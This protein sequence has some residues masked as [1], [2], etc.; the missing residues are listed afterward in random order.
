MIKFDSFYIIK[1]NLKT[2]LGSCGLERSVLT[3]T[4]D[5]LKSLH[6]HISLTI[7]IAKG[8]RNSME[9]SYFSIH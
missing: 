4:V 1:E 9:K 6:S 3:H 8:E 7:T 5:N 2:I